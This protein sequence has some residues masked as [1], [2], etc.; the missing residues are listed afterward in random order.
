MKLT[1][2]VGKLPLLGRRNWSPS[3]EISGISSDSRHVKQGDLFVACPGP[4]VNGHQFLLEA[5][6]KGARA[7][8][9]EKESTASLPEG[10]VF[11]R[12]SDAREALTHFLN[13]FYG[14]PSRKLTLVGVTGTNGKTT[15]AYLL[16]QLL[17]SQIPSAYIGTLGVQTPQGNGSLSNTT[18]G[19]EEL[20]S[21]LAGMAHQGVRSV[22]LEVSSH[23]LDQKRVHGLEFELVLFTQLTAEHLDYHGTLENYFQAK[24]LLFSQAPQPKKMLISRDSPYGRRLLAENS[25]AKSFSLTEEA[26]YRVREVL[27]NFEGSEFFFEGPRG[28]MKFRTR[29]P[30][31]HNVANT[32]AVLASLDLLGFDPAR[33]RGPLESFSGVPGRMER[34]EGKGY[35]VFVDYAHTPDAF[36]HVLSEAKRLQPRR[37]LTLFGCGGDRDPFKRPEMTRIAYHYSDCLILTSDNPRTEDPAEI[38]R[39]MRQGLPGGSPLPNVLEI[40]DRREAIGELLGLAEPGDVVFIL[41]KGHENDQILGTEKIPLDDR[42]IVRDLL[43]LRGRSRVVL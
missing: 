6:R 8:V 15:I 4:H 22:A 19:A 14:F 38:I 3:L 37:I 9:G 32:L 23:A 24:R 40:L 27:A 42:Q 31:I 10:A 16:N 13:H 26:D 2:L 28:K 43:K 11:L 25:K 5:F 29:L 18:P 7:G 34:M 1:Q 20:F 35:T 33:F 36:E 39:Q 41:G 12:V 17:G 21:L 30:L